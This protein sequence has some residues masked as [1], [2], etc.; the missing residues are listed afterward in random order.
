MYRTKVYSIFLVLSEKNPAH[1]PSNV[2]AATNL[3]FSVYVIGIACFDECFLFYVLTGRHYFL[4]K[5]IATLRAFP[6]AILLLS[7][8]EVF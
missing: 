4:Q 5:S 7:L 3:F 6:A 2:A 1:K 8:K